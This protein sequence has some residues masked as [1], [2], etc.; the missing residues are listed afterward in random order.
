[1]PKFP[2]G[3]NFPER[4]PRPRPGGLKTAVADA[5]EAAGIEAAPHVKAAPDVEAGPEIEAAAE[6]GVATTAAPV[7]RPEVH[8]REVRPREPNA[9]KEVG[10]GEVRPPQ[11]RGAAGKR[12]EMVVPQPG[13]AKVLGTAGAR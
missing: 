13:V 7:E 5:V 8:V 12:N 1:M 6:P 2:F 4:D 9:A 10:A 11:G 3:K